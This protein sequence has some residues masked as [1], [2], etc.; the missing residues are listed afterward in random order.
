M[1]PFSYF[2]I[3]HEILITRNQAHNIKQVP[4]H[5]SFLDH[6]VVP[7]WNLHP[8]QFELCDH[9]GEFHW[10]TSCTAPILPWKREKGEKLIN[11]DYEIGYVIIITKQLVNPLSW[12]AWHN[13][14]SSYFTQRWLHIYLVTKESITNPHYLLCLPFPLI[15]V[16]KNLISYCCY[17]FSNI[18]RRT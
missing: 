6:T 14:M 5:H 11:N 17:Y 9:Q 3:K 10:C 2:Y 4:V 8:N 15:F 7:Q 13:G 12:D 1:K 18:I 16:F